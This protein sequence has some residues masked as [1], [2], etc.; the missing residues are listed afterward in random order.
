VRVS[1]FSRTSRGPKRAGCRSPPR[2]SATW[3]TCD[4]TED[5]DEWGPE[6]IAE[7]VRARDEER[8]RLDREG[9]GE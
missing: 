5:E 2:S 9:W 1:G 7:Y 3:T 6:Q 4:G 8:E